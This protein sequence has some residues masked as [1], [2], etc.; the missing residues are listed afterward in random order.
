MRI[1]FVDDCD[2]ERTEAS[3]ELAE[4]D[5]VTVCSIRN[6]CDA[7]MSQ[8][9][10]LVMIDLHVPP[11]TLV[12]AVNLVQAAGQAKILIV[13]SLHSGLPGDSD[14]D[15]VA[16]VAK[17]SPVATATVID[18]GADNSQSNE[19]VKALYVEIV[20]ELRECRNLIGICDE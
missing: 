14:A 13:S 18:S 17:S 1:L 4:H 12:D 10:D 2:R 6:A 16:G 19:R 20:D 3:H 8:K 11:A 7:A 9:F 5:V 15:V